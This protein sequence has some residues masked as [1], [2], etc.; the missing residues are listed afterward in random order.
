LA[1]GADNLTG[2]SYSS[3]EA[4][5]G[6]G[7]SGSILCLRSWFWDITVE[8][9]SVYDITYVLLVESIDVIRPADHTLLFQ[10]ASSS[11]FE[12]GD[13]SNTSAILRPGTGPRIPVQAHG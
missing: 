1:S 12:I 9:I 5:A 8:S 13:D 11:M 6:D 2:R 7:K 10:R 3:L 4:D